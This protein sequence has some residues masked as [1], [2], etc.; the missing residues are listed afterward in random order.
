MPD[1]IQCGCG[2]RYNPATHSA[3]CP[4]HEPLAGSAVEPEPASEGE[5]G[6]DTYFDPRRR[7][8]SSQTG[9][10]TYFD[11]DPT[12]PNPRTA[13]LTDTLTPSERTAR[14]ALRGLKFITPFDLMES[15]LACIGQCLEALDRVAPPLNGEGE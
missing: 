10:D 6:K 11:P 2:K 13:P 4:D 5:T 14:E 7:P 1:D 3:V 15:H 9:K 12:S 8:T